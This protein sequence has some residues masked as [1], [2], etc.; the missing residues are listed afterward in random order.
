MSGDRESIMAAGMTGYVAKPVD[1]PTLTAA[2]QQALP[3]YNF[4]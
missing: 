4:V 3:S 2:I 1:L